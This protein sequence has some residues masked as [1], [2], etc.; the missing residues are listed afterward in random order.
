MVFQKLRV[1]GSQNIRD[2]GLKAA[3]N[4]ISCLTKYSTKKSLIIHYQWV[5]NRPMNDN[6][7]DIAAYLNLEQM[8]WYS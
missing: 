2:K 1:W 6:F 4:F 3:L 8:K 5:L 7:F